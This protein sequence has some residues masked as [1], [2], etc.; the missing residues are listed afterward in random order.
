MITAYIGLG[1]NIG[2]RLGNLSRAI[3]AIAHVP[4]SHVC[5]VS[6]AYETVPA[7]REE[8]SAFLNAVIEIETTL[9]S[10]TLLMR[11]NEI[12]DEMGRVRADVN[13]PRVIDLDLLLYDEEESTSE[14]LTLPHP[15]LLERDFVVTPLLEIAPEVELPDGTR[16]S[17]SSAVVGPVIR[18]FG[19][20]PD[21]GVAHNMPI[22]PTDWA[23]VAES[24]G[25]QTAIGGFDAQLQFKR[26]VLEQEGI[27]VAFE[28]FEPGLDIDVLGRP[29]TFR[30]VVPTDYAKRAIALLEQVEQTEP[31]TVVDE[32]A[33]ERE[34]IGSKPGS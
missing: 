30:L 1:S 24:E 10:D 8:Q 18:D 14:Y 21:A 26:Q 6:R 31:E 22:E 4:N 19:H 28:P 34:G 16:P 7:Y 12:E 11:L 9:E 25:P 23:A 13:G 2:D 33:D 27:P 20:I 32:L 29:R 17:R 5:H 3:D 15:G